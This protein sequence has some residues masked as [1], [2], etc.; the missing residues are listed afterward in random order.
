[1]RTEIMYSTLCNLTIYFGDNHHFTSADWREQYKSLADAINMAEYI[2]DNYFVL[3][4]RR[5]VIW[6]S[7]TGEVLAECFPDN[8]DDLEPEPEDDPEDYEDDCDYEIG[9]NPYLGCFTWD[10]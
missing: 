9:F 7:N 2:F 6:D 8:D 5:I 4:A 3:T 10:E 1:M